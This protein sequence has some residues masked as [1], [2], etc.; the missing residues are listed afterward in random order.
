[1]TLEE[2]VNCESANASNVNYLP[3]AT[4]YLENPEPMGYEAG[5][6]LEITSITFATFKGIIFPNDMD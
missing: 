6:D 5:S 3:F 1:M 2:S 4:Q